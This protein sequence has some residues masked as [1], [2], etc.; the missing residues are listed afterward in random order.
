MDKPDGSMHRQKYAPACVDC[1]GPFIAAC[2]F[3]LEMY[4]TKSKTKNKH[5]IWKGKLFNYTIAHRTTGLIGV[6]YVNVT[7]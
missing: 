4:F 2:S 7:H 5:L 1:E 6:Q 3:N